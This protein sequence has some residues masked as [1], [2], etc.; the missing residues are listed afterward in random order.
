MSVESTF[1]K[2]DE[3]NIQEYIRKWGPVL[4]ANNPDPLLSEESRKLCA[5]MLELQFRHNLNSE[6]MGYYQNTAYLLIKRLIMFSSKK[7]LNLNRLHL[8]GG[9]GCGDVVFFKIKTINLG[10]FMFDAKG[11][12]KVVNSIFEQLFEHMAPI[13]GEGKFLV[14]PLTFLVDNESDGNILVRTAIK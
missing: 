8:L 7:L 4:D 5:H 11:F 2:I 1:Q 3:N 14:E 12:E 10:A 13:I 9:E 6:G